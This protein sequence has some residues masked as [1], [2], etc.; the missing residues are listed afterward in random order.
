MASFRVRLRR[1]LASGAVRSLRLLAAGKRRFLGRADCL[2]VCAMPKSGSTFLVNALVEATGHVPLFL[3]Y[4]HLN[5]QDLYLP[6]LVDA[7]S[8]PLVAHQH[9]RATRANLALIR[10]FH[11]RPVILVRD[12]ADAAVSL[13]DHLER[14]ARQTPILNLG[15]EALGW[16]RAGRLDAVVDLAMPWYVQFWAGWAAAL[17]DG[18]ADGMVLRYAELAASPVEAVERVL[19]FHGIRRARPALEAA[20]ARAQGQGSRLNRG[21]GGRGRAELTERQHA[22]IARLAGYYPAVDFTPVGVPSDG[23]AADRPAEEDR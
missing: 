2:F 16:D 1:G 8:L 9:T 14:E 23:V 13:A 11:I 18:R 19:A 7:W 15:D 12:L 17:A 5:E 20:V 21:I 10:E 6:R 22:R 3:G 4:D